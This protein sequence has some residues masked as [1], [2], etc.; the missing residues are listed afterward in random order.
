LMLCGG[1]GLVGSFGLLVSCHGM[2]LF[3]VEKAGICFV[4]AGIG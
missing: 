3:W 4:G 2:G 1:R